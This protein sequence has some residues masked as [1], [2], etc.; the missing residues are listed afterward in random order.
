MAVGGVDQCQGVGQFDGNLFDQQ[1]NIRRGTDFAVEIFENVP[2]Q[3]RC[4]LF[5]H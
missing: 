2:F 3:I 4:S 1:R 5:V